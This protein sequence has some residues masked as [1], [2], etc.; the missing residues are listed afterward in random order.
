M[1]HQA[2][3]FGKPGYIGSLPH[4][5]RSYTVMSLRHNRKPY[6]LCEPR[7]NLELGFRAFEKSAPRLYNGLPQNMKNSPNLE[8]F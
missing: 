7:V 3:H 5:F 2:I 1:T 6:R 4:D 8:I